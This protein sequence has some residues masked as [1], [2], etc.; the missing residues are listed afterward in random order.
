[1][2]EVVS[3]LAEVNKLTNNSYL[4]FTLMTATLALIPEETIQIT[5]TD[6]L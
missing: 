6:P 5:F 2:K 1:V 3:E 4:V